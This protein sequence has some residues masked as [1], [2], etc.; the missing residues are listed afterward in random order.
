MKA[1]NQESK[2]V[3]KVLARFARSTSRTV[4]KRRRATNTRSARWVKDPARKKLR[5]WVAFCCKY[6][7]AN[8][9]KPRLLDELDRHLYFDHKTYER[10][11]DEYVC[12]LDA[13]RLV[14]Q[15]LAEKLPRTEFTRSVGR[16]FKRPE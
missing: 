12:T 15:L 13:Q 11:D 3:A 6:V 14:A 9:G 5:G 8:W 10:S 1:K 4:F 16:F 2:R 7:N